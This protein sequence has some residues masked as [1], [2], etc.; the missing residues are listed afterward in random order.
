VNTAELSSAF[1]RAAARY[2]LLTSLNPGYDRH[3]AE[4]A[5]VLAAVP[6]GRILDLCCGTGR[7]TSALEAAYPSA[8]V[9]GLDASS[10]MLEKARQLGLPLVRG[11]AAAPPVGDGVFDAALVAYGLR[12]MTDPDAFLAGVRSLLRPGGRLAVHDYAL[13]TARSRVTW[14]VVAHLV[15]IPGGF[16][17]T[18]SAGLYRY[19][20]RSVVRFDRADA[21]VDR[22]RRAG[23]V[24]V[25]RH[26]TSHW[27]K[28]ITHT[29]TAT[30]P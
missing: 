18:G 19:L 20:Y 21:V 25:E 26:D 3:L 28:G 8:A 23:F 7:S 11:D 29:F 17:A 24:D 4:A 10:G 2:D 30:L 9:V 27:Q 22:L 1:D 6:K 15:I 12:N 13:T 16:V 14:W 5:R